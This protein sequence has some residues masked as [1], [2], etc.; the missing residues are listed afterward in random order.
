MNDRPSRSKRVA[1]GT[2]LAWCRYPLLATARLVQ[3]PP[4]MGAQEST[5]F[6]ASP[7][8]PSAPAGNR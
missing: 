7:L 8:T 2:Q 3:V 4:S 6:A 5:W 1:D